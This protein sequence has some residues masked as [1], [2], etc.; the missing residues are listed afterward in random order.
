VKA[1]VQFFHLFG[2]FVLTSSLSWSQPVFRLQP[3]PW[4]DSLI[5][6]LSVEEQIGQLFMVPA[7]SDPKH[8]YFNHDQVLSWIQ[9]YHVGGIIFFQGGPIHQI[10]YTN[11]Y[12]SKSKIP[13]LIGMDAEWSLS[14]RL[15]STILYPRQMTLGAIQDKRTVYEFAQES[16]RQLKRLGVHLSFSP[17]VDINNNAKNPV[18]SNRSFGEDRNQ[19]LEASLAFMEGLQNE[20]VLACAKHFPGHGDTNTDSHEDMPVIPFSKSRLDSLELF[21]YEPMI[22]SG[23]ASVMVGHLSVPAIENRKGIPATLSRSIVTD[24]LKGEMQFQGL[25]IT[26]ALNMQGVAKHFPAGQMEALAV[27]AGND[28]LLFPSNIPNAIEQI[29]ARMDSGFISTDQIRESCYKI[30]QTKEWCKLN[31]PSRISEENVWQDINGKRAVDINEKIV[32]QSLVLLCNQNNSLKQLQDE[33]RSKVLVMI[34]G[35]TINTLAATFKEYVNCKVVRMPTDIDTTQQQ[36]T[37]D[38]LSELAAFDDVIFAWVN[39]SSKANKHFGISPHQMKWIAQWKTKSNKWFLL[40]A[41]PYALSGLDSLDQVNGIAVGFQDD[42]I[43]E[44]VM[45]EACMGARSFNGVLPVSINDQ[46]KSGWGITSSGGQL[47]SRGVT[48]SQKTLEWVK[49]KNVVIS[50]TKEYTENFN[51]QSSAKNNIQTLVNWPEMDS[52]ANLGLSSGAY[53]G[54]RVLVAHKGKI[55]YDRCYGYSDMHRQRPVKDSTIYDLASITKL[56]ASSLVMMY[57]VDHQLLDIHLTLGDYLT[58]PKKSPYAKLRVKDIMMHQAGL[59]EFIPFHLKANRFLS[60]ELSGSNTLPVADH[61]YADSMI[62]A[63]MRD[64]ILATP[65]SAD[66]GKPCAYKYSDVGFFFL[67]EIAERQTH[68]K[69]EEILSTEFYQPMQ[70]KSFGYNPLQWADSLYIAPTEWDTLFRKQ[71]IKGYVHDPGA[72]LMGG[73]AGHAGLFGNAYD[74]AKVMHMLMRKGSFG[75]HQLIQSRTFDLF[76]TRHTK[77]NRRGLILDK[78]TLDHIGG[79]CSPLASDDSFGHTG[80]T[81][82][83]CWADPENEIVFVFLSNRIHPNADNKKLLNLNIRT[84]MHSVIYRQLLTEHS[85]K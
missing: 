17:V 23:L 81:G 46:W 43:T 71:L 63:W 30:L 49:T 84:Q 11:L 83:M 61:L 28:V 85:S 60:T 70:L 19:V 42:P 75:N 67:K 57:L 45:A 39:T 50:K 51:D 27:E 10:K 4:A 64:E 25:T 52:L 44:R 1:F 53:P 69:W 3:T 13:L 31:H 26:D 79:S 47:L 65:L 16:A 55:V 78:P 32:E 24:L 58:F 21:P 22:Q 7:W 82:T 59:K 77:G 15:D 56:A 73:V 66:P 14:M 20:G 33:R 68:R 72:A 62:T 48:S 37:M 80:F 54:C 18:I 74:L 12:Q 34:G 41:N 9:D 29:K 2:C 5:K 6:T 8:Q 40:F 38:W 36:I 76:N 35:D